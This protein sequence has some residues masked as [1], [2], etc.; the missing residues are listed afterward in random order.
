VLIPPVPAK[1]PPNGQ[2]AP[3]VV[4][5]GLAVFG[6]AHIRFEAN[7]CR[8]TNPNAKPLSE[9]EGYLVDGIAK[10]IKDQGLDLMVMLKSVNM[11][12]R[13]DD[14]DIISGIRVQGTYDFVDP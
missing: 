2:G 1:A 14:D 12:S 13:A 4:D 9:D 8:W 5:S 10:Q 6:K 7:N 3:G 11:E